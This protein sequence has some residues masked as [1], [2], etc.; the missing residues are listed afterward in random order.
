MSKIST[1]NA[2]L[3]VFAF[4]ILIAV[5]MIYTGNASVAIV[6]LLANVVVIG[7]LLYGTELPEVFKDE[8]VSDKTID[9]ND[10]KKICDKVSCFSGCDDS[11]DN[12]YF[13]K[14]DEY[15][16][17]DECEIRPDIYVD[18]DP[19][20]RNKWGSNPKYSRCYGPLSY[21]L[22]NC[23]L[24]SRMSIDERMARQGRARNNEKRV[25]DGAVSKTADYYRKHF[26]DELDQ[27]EKKPWWGNNDF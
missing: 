1:Q 27:E 7:Y 14:C 22:N 21:E 16:D 25:I 10:I 5:A 13:E 2:E 12:S 8:D 23:D 24:Y 4:I 9:I 18:A 20:H 11:C 6:L 3:L 17:C 26:A 19:Y 15:E